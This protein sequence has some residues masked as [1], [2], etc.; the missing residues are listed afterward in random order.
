MTDAPL[1][2]VERFRRAFMGIEGWLR[3]KYG[4]WGPDFQNFVQLL[5]KATDKRLRGRMQD[6]LMAY[7][8]LRNS[9]SHDVRGG[10]YM[11]VPQDAVVVEIERIHRLLTA[12]PRIDGTFR[13][14]VLRSSP[15]QP[16]A[17]L[18]ELMGH[19]DISQVPIYE[20]DRFRGLLTSHAVLRWLAGHIGDDLVS[21]QDARVA[22][23]LPYLDPDGERCDFVPIDFP[24]PEAVQRFSVAAEHG[25]YLFALLITQAGKPDQRPV[26]I[27]A[28][29]DVPEA[30]RVIDAT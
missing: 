8:Q 6:D 13:F 14:E 22:D 15:D 4:S 7:A 19:R 29:S 30:L 1:D 24:L 3:Q 16:L 26:G 12:P 10:E 2:N 23:V 17:P 9:L 20:V 11:A 27:M 21:L 25:V 28:V 5:R 18:L